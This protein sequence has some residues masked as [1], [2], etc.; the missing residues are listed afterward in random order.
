MSP[1]YLYQTPCA[2]ASDEKTSNVSPIVYAT[3]IGF[4]ITTLVHSLQYP[5][6]L[7]GL[8]ML[9]KRQTFSCKG[10]KKG[11]K[12]WITRNQINAVAKGIFFILTISIM[13]GLFI[14][15][16][17]IGIRAETMLSCGSR[18]INIFYA[19]IS[20]SFLIRVLSLLIVILMACA[21]LAVAEIWT[22]GSEVLESPRI[23]KKFSESQSTAMMTAYDHHA[24][25]SIKYKETGEMVKSIKQAFELY[26]P[27]PWIHFLLLT[28]VNKLLSEEQNQQGV[29]ADVVYQRL[30]YVMP[31]YLYRIIQ[32]FT[33]FVFAVSMNQNHTHFLKAMREKQ[34]KYDIENPDME[35]T[36]YTSIKACHGYART[37]Q[38]EREEDYDFVPRIVFLGVKVSV[39]DSTYVIVLLIGGLLAVAGSFI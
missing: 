23:S 26:F 35:E 34:L 16:P 5:V 8:W 37:L 17:A 1:S 32:L 36:E 9:L 22:S 19:L 20:L 12:K 13:C 14:A 39:N 33:L 28:A 11:V 30:A 24:T 3:T 15:T 21:T 4:G 38:I 25:L 10:T 7:Y 18:N 2:N 27:L 29:N 31:Y 6:F